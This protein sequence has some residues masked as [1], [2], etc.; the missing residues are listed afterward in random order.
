MRESIK[1]GLATPI[2]ECSEDPGWSF[3]KKFDKMF[4]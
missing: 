4:T 1:E 3:L 2:E